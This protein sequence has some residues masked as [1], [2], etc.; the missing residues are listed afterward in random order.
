MV[1]LAPLFDDGKNVA[2]NLARVLLIGQ[3]IDRRDAGK[4]RELLDIALRIRPNDCAVNHTRQ[5][6]RRVLD[7]FT[8]T[9]L[10]VR[11]I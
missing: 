9:E 8:A 7:Q 4:L 10:R 5:D 11:R 2:Q 1:D 3:R 6:A